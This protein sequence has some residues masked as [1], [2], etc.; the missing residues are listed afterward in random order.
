MKESR[1]VSQIILAVKTHYPRAWVRKLA[2]RYTRGLPDILI[3][4]PRRDWGLS[5]SIGVLWVE[6]KSASGKCSAIQLAEQ[7][8]IMAVDAE[9][10]EVIVAKSV[11]EVL[12]ALDELR[13]VGTKERMKS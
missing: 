12:K 7:E 3:L 1:L 9:G 13:A 6:T 4:F 10:V 5:E 2:D 11:D 8:K